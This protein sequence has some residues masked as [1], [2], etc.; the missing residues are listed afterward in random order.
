M[1]RVRLWSLAS[2]PSTFGAKMCEVGMWLERLG[3]AHTNTPAP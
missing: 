3:A 1:L 2:S